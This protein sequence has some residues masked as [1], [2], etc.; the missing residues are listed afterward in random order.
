[1]C[2][3]S[4]HQLIKLRETYKWQAQTLNKILENL[5]KT[6][7]LDTCRGM[8]GCGRVDSI[9]MDEITNGEFEDGDKEP[10]QDDGMFCELNLPCSNHFSS[11][12]V[13]LLIHEQESNKNDN[14]A[15]G[16]SSGSTQYDCEQLT[17]D[18]SKSTTDSP[19][20]SEN[21]LDDNK[22]KS[23]DIDLEEEEPKNNN[24]DSNSN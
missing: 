4:G 20:E 24:V 18:K 9:Y 2:K 7:N 10:N 21:G 15:S 6:L 19:R 14:C 16:S 23:N 1:V 17:E 22:G 5:P 13:T 12:Y 3:F 11:E 8:S